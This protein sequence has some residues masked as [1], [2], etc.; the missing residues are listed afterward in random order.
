MV[1]VITSPTQVTPVPLGTVGNSPALQNLPFFKTSLDSAMVGFGQLQGS[2]N[3]QPFFV[4][5]TVL[6][7]LV[8]VTTPGTP[9]RWEDFSN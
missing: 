8:Q 3:T 9:A 1:Q 7:S 4:D 6:N 5:T 2:T